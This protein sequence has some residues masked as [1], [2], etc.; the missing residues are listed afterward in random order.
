MADTTIALPMTRDI[1]DRAWTCNFQPM[2]EGV[3]GPAASPRLV[4]N[5]GPG[6]LHLQRRRR[7]SPEQAQA[8]GEAPTPILEMIG[9]SPG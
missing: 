9:A 8:E 6:A 4:S 3:I 2:P 1:S 5:H 7:L